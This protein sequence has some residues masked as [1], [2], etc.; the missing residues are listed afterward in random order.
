MIITEAGEGLGDLSDL[1][2]HVKLVHNVLN[3]SKKEQKRRQ[4]KGPA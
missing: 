3:Q 1:T 4:I 2:K